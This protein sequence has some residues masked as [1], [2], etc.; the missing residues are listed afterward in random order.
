MKKNTLL[1]FWLLGI[2]GYL[3]S[4]SYIGFLSDNYSGVNAVIS[5]PAN[6]NSS[7]YKLDINLGGVSAFASNDYF[8]VNVFK[9]LKDGYD[10][11]LEA[12]RS[13]LN[14]NRATGNVDVLGPSFMFSLSQ[15]S[16]LALFTR[17]RFF[18][19]ANEINGETIASIDD[20]TT[21]DFTVDED[22]FNGVGHAWAEFGVAYAT[23]ILNKNN[24]KLKGGISLKYLKGLASA[25]AFGEDVT[26]NYDA[27]GTDLGG[28]QTTGS[29]TSSG[30][31]NLARFDEFDADNYDYKSPNN[32]SGFALDIGVS[33][34]WHPDDL[35]TNT[36]KFK[37]GLSVTD[38]GFINYKN[39]VREV[40]N[41]TNTNVSEEDYENSESI[42]E[43]LNNFYTRLDGRTGYKI[44]LPSALNFNLDWNFRKNLFLNFNVDMPLISTDRITANRIANI[45]SL[46][47]RYESKWFS[48]YLPFS[49]VQ[50]NGFRMGAGFRAGPI[51]AG[52]GSL[53]SAFASNNN[54][55]ADVY[56]GVKVPIYK[57]LPKD[58]DEDGIVDK[59]DNCPEIFGPKD[60]GGC[61][62][63][64]TD[65]DGILDNEDACP[66]DAGPIENKGCPWKDTD[67]DGVLDKDDNCVE[68]A[69]TI[70]NNGC[71]EGE[72]T[73][74][75]QNN[76]NAFARTILF[77]SGTAMIKPESNTILM[78]IVQ[79]LKTYPSAGFT[80]EG[81]TDSTGGEDLNRELSEA[82]ANSVKDFLVKNGIDANRLL[83]VGY[84]ESKPIFSNITNYGR[85][86]NR[87]VEINLID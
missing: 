43:F 18:I 54:Q 26:F 13:P 78:E 55:Q 25:Y 29:F 62:W 80:I 37:L 4:Q 8:G 57:N 59:L 82:R 66:E 83:T 74:E 3:Q 11:N 45:V 77:D 19:N 67:G 50:R 23:T 35:N 9:A 20:D 46:T 64:D 60:N 33:Y 48:F 39:G 24:R 2:F 12:T 1:V 71:P 53:I 72:V 49:V 52:S 17:A 84:G 73:E 28:G 86:R 22:D 79:I 85:A 31:L 69:G 44:D 21:N 36:Y 42:N 30:T 16:T 6:I 58:K 51:Y 40:Y 14:D 63:G 5:N 32:A 38:I 65:E 7:P 34:Q 76:L 75:I 10:F 27:D 61:P 15:N 81:H 56:A 87:R 70:P 68:E 41:I 47:P